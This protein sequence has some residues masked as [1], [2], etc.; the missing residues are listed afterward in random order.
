[1]TQTERKIVEIYKEVHDE[2]PDKDMAFA[3]ETTA[4]RVRIHRIKSDCDCGDVA[5]ALLN[6]I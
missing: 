5:I 2:F 6:M 4:A 3:L 1:M